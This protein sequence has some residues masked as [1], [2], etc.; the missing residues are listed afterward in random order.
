MIN[1]RKIERDAQ[2]LSGKRGTVATRYQARNVL[3]LIALMRAARA[4]F[5]GLEPLRHSHGI[6]SGGEIDAWL[7]QVQDEE[8]KP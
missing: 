7:A 3:T 8:P 6:A 4:L 2:Y 5:M 1:L